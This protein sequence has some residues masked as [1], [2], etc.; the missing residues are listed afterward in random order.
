M[1]LVGLLRNVDELMTELGTAPGMHSILCTTVIYSL[2]QRLV[3][4]GQSYRVPASLFLSLTN[5]L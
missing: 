5:T 4:A 3:V 2:L 1:N